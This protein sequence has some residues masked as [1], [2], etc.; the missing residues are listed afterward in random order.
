MTKCR[1]CHKEIEEGFAGVYCIRCDDIITESYEL[2]E[3]HNDT[4]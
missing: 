3:A 4:S 1:M 2:E